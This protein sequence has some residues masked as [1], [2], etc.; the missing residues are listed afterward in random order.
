MAMLM[1]SPGCRF[2]LRCTSS[3][4]PPQEASMVF[5]GLNFLQR[6]SKSFALRSSL[7]RLNCRRSVSICISDMAE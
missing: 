6:G 1:V 3:R 7:T 5:A 4:R 2:A